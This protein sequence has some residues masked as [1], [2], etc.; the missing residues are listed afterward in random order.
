MEE[1]QVVLF[2]LDG[3]LTDSGEGIVN[4][5][6]YALEKFGTPAEEGASLQCF[7]GPPLAEQ[8]QKYCHVSKED[9]ERLV[10]YYREYYA[11]KGIYENRLYNGITELLARLKGSGKKLAIATSKPERYARMIA[12]YFGIDGYFAYIGG[13]HMD[14][15]RTRKAEVIAYVLESMG[16]CNLETAVMI[17]DREHDIAGAAQTGIDSIGVLYGY[18]EEKELQGADRIAKTPGEI[19]EI[20]EEG[21][22]ENTGNCF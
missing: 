17:G 12:E 14:G 21:R 19:A 4:S 5:V 22:T 2:D 13:A 16:V 9:G 7:I 18:G 15:R 6:R 10:E 11:D 20:L 1:K 3:T 8:F